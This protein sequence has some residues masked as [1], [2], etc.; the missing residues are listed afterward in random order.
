MPQWEHVNLSFG[1]TV[2]F[3]LYQQPKLLNTVVRMTSP[4]NLPGPDPALQRG[5]SLCPPVLGGKPGKLY[6]Q[7]PWEDRWLCIQ[8]CT[9]V[10]N[11]PDNFV[12]IFLLAC[13]NYTGFH[14]SIFTHLFQSQSLLL[15][16]TLPCSPFN[17]CSSSQP[18]LLLSS[19]VFPFVSMGIQVIS[20]E[21]KWENGQGCRH[22]FTG[23]WA[24]HHWLHHWR[25][26][27]FLHQLLTTYNPR[28]GWGPVSPLYSRGSMHN[29]VQVSQLL[30]VQEFNSHGMFCS[31]HSTLV[32][33]H[34]VQHLIPS[35][36]FPAP[37]KR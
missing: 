16:V 31:Q 24:P 33:T 2:S 37:W 15:S 21:L 27:F 12:S 18:S 4:M 9:F 28:G 35:L 3:S 10:Y 26:A 14:C 30:V 7:A 20:G 8:Y 11:Y 19:C 22:L 32:S 5:V 6:L 1:R 13:I 25:N 17:C 23:F 36:V 29:L 34:L